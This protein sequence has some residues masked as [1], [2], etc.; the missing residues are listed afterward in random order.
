MS[1]IEIAERLGT[2]TAIIQ[3]LVESIEQKNKSIKKIYMK[4]ALRDA[5][6]FLA[7]HKKRFG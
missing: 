7:Q 3:A 4:L 5:K 6:K 2:A 1:S